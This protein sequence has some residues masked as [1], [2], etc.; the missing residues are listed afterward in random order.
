MA[1]A[2]AFDS[3]QPLGSKEYWN[4][5]LAASFIGLRAF[6]I[7]SLANSIILTSYH[8]LREK[9]E[10]SRRIW[11]VLLFPLAAHCTVTIPH[12]GNTQMWCKSGTQTRVLGKWAKTEDIAVRSFKY[13]EHA[14]D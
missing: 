5:I 3:R 1:S 12:L 4:L 7:E 14:T 10:I 9:I 11:T 13:F 2:L 6:R 8:V